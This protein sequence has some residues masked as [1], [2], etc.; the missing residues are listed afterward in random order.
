MRWFYTELGQD[1]SKANRPKNDG[2]FQKDKHFPKMQIAVQSPNA[3]HEHPSF[4]IEKNL[5]I[6]LIWNNCRIDFHLKKI[7]FFYCFEVPIPLIE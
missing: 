1:F 3:V 2:C 5:Y 7:D 6:F 4:Y